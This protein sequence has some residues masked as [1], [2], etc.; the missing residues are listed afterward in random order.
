MTTDWIGQRLTPSIT[1][2]PAQNNDLRAYL[3]LI[4][5]TVYFDYILSLFHNLSH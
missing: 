5:T 4:D 1:F 2:Y 3:S